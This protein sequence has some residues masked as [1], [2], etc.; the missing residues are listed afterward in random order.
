MNIFK[1]IIEYIDYNWPTRATTFS[2]MYT[3]ISIKKMYF[4]KYRSEL[5]NINGPAIEI[6]DTTGDI[7]RYQYYIN[8][9]NYSKE[10]YYKAIGKEYILMLE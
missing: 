8:N 10:E 4:K 1:K 6:E 5:H 9:I 7:I 2:T 3:N